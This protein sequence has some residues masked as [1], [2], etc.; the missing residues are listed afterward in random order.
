MA[1]KQLSILHLDTTMGWRGGQQQLIY[2]HNGL[3][4]QKIKSG[5]ACPENSKLASHF[6]AKESPTFLI[7]SRRHYNIN[8]AIKIAKYMHENKY[9]YLHAHS[10][11]AL[12]LALL[13][14][15]LLP[16]I[17]L[18]A[19]RRVDF[20]IKKP[21]IGSFKYNNHLVNKIICIS[22][23]IKKVME[24]DGVAKTKL[25]TVH[26]GIDI[27]RFSKV[28][29]NTAEFRK[30]LAIA[31]N[32]VIVGTIAAL[33]GHKD[34][35]TLLHTARQVLNRSDNITFIALGDG[36][37]QDEI[38]D[39]HKELKLGNRFRLLGFRDDIAGF[40]HLFDI[41]ILTSKMEGMGTTLLDAQS[42]GLP[43]V[44]TKA[45]GIVEV[46]RN[47]ENGLLANVGDVQDLTEKVL[48][49][50]ANAKLRQKL[51]ENGQDFVKEF[52]YRKTVRE[53]IDVYQNLSHD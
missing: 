37:E 51:G 44:A 14:K 4:D 30:K 5:L 48:H 27:Q 10:S 8:S 45:G 28:S 6:K 39:L 33:A 35:H 18:I 50:A 21:V 47:G 7:K 42:A 22:H 53:T 25:V 34:Y 26:S 16:N 32:N 29:A 46:V 12:T 11:H 9:N 40:L 49:L 41:F 20:S 31:K 15:L 13:V 2:L 43:I 1:I 19:A 3:L 24:N 17:F 23:A 52:D 38:S 36:P